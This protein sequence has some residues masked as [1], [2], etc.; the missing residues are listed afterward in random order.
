MHLRAEA[1]VLA[2]R[3]HGEHGAVVRAFTRSDGVQP[4]YVRGGRSRQ[5]RPVLQPT[6]TIAGEWRARTGEQLAA[7]TI[8]PVHSR[9]A[10]HGEPLPAAA[11]AWVAA[12]T[13][14]V[15]P[16]AQAY[17]RLYDALAAVLDAIEA[18]PAA[19]GWAGALARYELLL[20][21][22]L[23]FGLDLSACVVTGAD[24][25]LGFVSPRSG[26]AVSRGA[27]HGYETRLFALPAFL[28][29]GGFAD[30]PDIL[31]ALAITGHFLARDLL[32][33]RRAEPLVARERLIAMLKRAVA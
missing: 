24:D 25:D 27:A 7:L 15:L 2:V 26:G 33:D 29:E 20:L 19:R 22:E 9:A 12:L 21:A 14:T 30:W 31:A 16:E 1:I 28:T 23:G 4:G 32:T 17:P 13:A 11:L 3:T 18:A 5:M 6:N 10:L 8:E